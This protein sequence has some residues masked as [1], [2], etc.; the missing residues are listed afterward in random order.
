M[1]YPPHILF[2]KTLEYDVLESYLERNLIPEEKNIIENYIIE[3]SFNCKL[4]NLRY[5]CKMKN[6]CVPILTNLDGNCLFESLVYLGIS[7]NVIQLRKMMSL[8]LYMYKDYKYFVPNDRTLR[9]IFNDTNEVT[10]VKS[11]GK[12]YMYTYE[13]MCQDLSNLCAW[14]KLPME[15]ILMIISYVFKLEIIIINNLSEYESK[16]NMFDNKDNKFN[17]KTI[18]IGKIDEAHYFPLFDEQYY[19]ENELLYYN[20]YGIQLHNWVNEMQKLK[21]EEYNFLS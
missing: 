4:K 7:S 15:L 12:Y 18:Y 19:G 17:I 8:L 5:I 10:Y 9:E 16:I 21:I 1:E 14:N 3:T 11:K 13:T 2:P 6:L 20:N